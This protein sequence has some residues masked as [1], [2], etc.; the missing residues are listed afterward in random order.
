M[1][2]FREPSAQHANASRNGRHVRS[3]GFSPF[4][5]RQS[6]HCE[7]PVRRPS[8]TTLRASA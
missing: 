4:Q 6:A 7:L 5:T 8:A 1:M 3:A 2:G